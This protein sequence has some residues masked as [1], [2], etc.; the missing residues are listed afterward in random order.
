M[1]KGNNMNIEFSFEIFPPATLEGF[2]EKCQQFKK[3]E[4]NFISVTFG[5]AGTQQ[6]RTLNVIQNLVANSMASVPHISCINMSKQKILALLHS[7]RHL[8]IKRLIVVRGDYPLKGSD[9]A[10]HDFNFAE[11]LIRYIRATTGDYFHITIAAY[12]EFH[13][14]AASPKSDLENLK[15]KI[16]AGANSAIT[17]YFFNSDAYFSFVDYCENLNINIAIT[18]GILPITE[19]SKLLR[20]SNACGAEIP[21]WLN[22]RLENYSGDAASFKA[23]GIEI[24][25]RLC[26]QLLSRGVQNLHFYTLNQIE[27]VTT[28]LKNLG[29]SCC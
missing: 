3:L 5:A 12:P 16:T 2:R 22:K 9:T 1:Y 19:Y 6:S 13:P 18:P 4:P 7:Y 24:T 11:E 23:F 14:Q 15:R 20:F 27:P 29:L 25:T 10:L 21:L 17:Q 28:I 8:G 26:E